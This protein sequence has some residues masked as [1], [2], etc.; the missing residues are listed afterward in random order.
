MISTYA[1]ITIKST[2][3]NDDG[4]EDDSI[5]GFEI[6]MTIIAI[7]LVLFWKRRK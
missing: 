6:F 4:G 2:D 5:P 3:Q 7:S 1:N